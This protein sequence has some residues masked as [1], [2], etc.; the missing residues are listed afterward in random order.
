MDL[1]LVT[2]TDVMTWHKIKTLFQ[3][4]WITAHVN[5]TLNAI[6][7]LLPQWTK[8]LNLSQELLVPFGRTRLYFYSASVHFIFPH[9]Y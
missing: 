2:F 7:I 8:L 5:S 3:R 1:F 9:I 4:L 6:N